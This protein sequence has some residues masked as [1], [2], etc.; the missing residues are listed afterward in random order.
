MYRLMGMNGGDPTGVS[1]QANSAQSVDCK[2][3]GSCNEVV[4]LISYGGDC[5]VDGVS[6]FWQFRIDYLDEIDTL[7]MPKNFF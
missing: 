7:F 4:L 3:V 1:D 5:K 6:F 2:C